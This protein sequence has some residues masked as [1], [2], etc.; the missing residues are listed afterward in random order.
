MFHNWLSWPPALSVCLS[1]CQYV[2]LS[3]P[4]AATP[5][6]ETTKSLTANAHKSVEKKQKAALPFGGPR[7]SSCCTPH[8]HTLRTHTHMIDGHLA[9]KLTPELL[10]LWAGAELGLRF[11]RSSNIGTAIRVTPPL[12]DG[13]GIWNDADIQLGPVWQKNE[14]K[15]KNVAPKTK[16]ENAANA[17]THTN[18]HTQLVA[19]SSSWSW[20]WKLMRRRLRFAPGY[21]T[22]SETR[23]NVSAFGE[24]WVMHVNYE[25]ATKSLHF[26]GSV[27]R[28]SWS[29]CF[30]VRSWLCS[31]GFDSVLRSRWLIAKGARNKQEVNKS[32][33][34]RMQCWVHWEKRGV[35]RR[36]SKAGIVVGYKTF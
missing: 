12:N 16:L 20:S 3:V 14:S 32:N 31:L 21:L 9:H 1:A 19:A 7:S 2:C 23:G 10:V 25:Y 30:A 27:T 28:R 18:T 4:S 22:E 33:S 13:A 35:K 29:W 11:W 15:I 17:P 36:L 8:T 34:C 26:E 24:S 5:F 6:A